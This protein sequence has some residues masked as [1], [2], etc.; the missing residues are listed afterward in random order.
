LNLE[1]RIENILVD[2]LFEKFGISAEF[3]T[4]DHVIS[5]RGYDIFTFG[6]VPDHAFAVCWNPE[7]FK[8]ADPLL[9]DKLQAPAERCIDYIRKETDYMTPMRM[10]KWR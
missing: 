4:A 2:W 5:W 9:F 3:Q 7:V 6:E 10:A 1:L 8:A